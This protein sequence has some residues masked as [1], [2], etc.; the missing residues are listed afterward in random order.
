MAGREITPEDLANL[1]FV[2][3]VDGARRIAA[4]LTCTRC[5]AYQAVDSDPS[6]DPS[7]M[8]QLAARLLNQVGWRAD[9]QGRALCPDCAGGAD[10]PA[11]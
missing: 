1:E 2:A 8:P 11:P 9:V 10:H 6:L 5:G 4:D 7:T 3:T